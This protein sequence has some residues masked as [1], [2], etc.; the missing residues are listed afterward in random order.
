VKVFQET[1]RAQ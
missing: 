1:R